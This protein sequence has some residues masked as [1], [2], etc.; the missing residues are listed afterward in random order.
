MQMRDLIA[1]LSRRA[2]TACGRFGL[3]YQDKAFPPSRGILQ[4]Y[5]CHTTTPGV[6]TTGAVKNECPV[7]M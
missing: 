5:I 4:K 1:H 7:H 6:S 3:G 2:L